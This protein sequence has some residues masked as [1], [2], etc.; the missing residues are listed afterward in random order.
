[1]NIADLVLLALVLALMY[2]CAKSL[3]SKKSSCSSCGCGKNCAGCMACGHSLK[4]K[5]V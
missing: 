4:N 5:R 1:M 2:A 3:F